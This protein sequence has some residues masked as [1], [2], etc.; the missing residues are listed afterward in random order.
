[1]WRSSRATSELT[2]WKASLALR[3]ATANRY[4]TTAP[5]CIASA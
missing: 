5:L 2:E 3:T 1:M 4:D